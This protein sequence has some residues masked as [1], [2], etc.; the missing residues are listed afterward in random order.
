MRSV[1]PTISSGKKTKIF[2]VST[3]YG[4][5]HFHKMWIDAIERRNLYKFLEVKWDR[6]PGRDN[7]WKEET[8]KNIGPEAFSQE[9]DIQFI[10]S[11]GTL[12]DPVKLRNMIHTNPVVSDDFLRIYKEPD[13]ERVYIEVIDTSEGL[14]LDASVCTMFDITTMPYEVA[15]IYQSTTIDPHLLPEIAVNLAQKYNEAYILCELNSVGVLVTSIIWNDLEYENMLW[16]TMNGRKG[17]VLGAG[18]AGKSNMGLKTSPQTKRIGCSVLKTLIESDQLI[19][20]DW[21]LKSE[22]STF[23]REGSTY[24]GQSDMPDDIVMTLVIFAWITNQTYFREL[25][26][27]ESMALRAKL[28]KD[29]LNAVNE[30]ISPFGIVSD[31]LDDEQD[32][33]SDM[34]FNFEHGKREMADFLR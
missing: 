22:L 21:L 5:N 8:I 7:Q 34:I 29:S 1:Y 30:M 18:F 14:G 25:T 4:M 28:L 33:T 10:G 6:V 3:P 9:F 23:V 16:T 15:A 27:I 32:F 20:N 12:I 31:G 24:K 13:P 17:Q 11:A 19:I 2:I 26:E